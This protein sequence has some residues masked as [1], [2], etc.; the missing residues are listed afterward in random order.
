MSKGIR[1]A[2]LTTF[3]ALSAQRLAGEF[4]ETTETLSPGNVK[5]RRAVCDKLVADFKITL[6]SA[7]S[8]YNA[9]FQHCKKHNPELTVN[10]GRAAD[11]IGGRKRKNADPVVAEAG[12]LSVVNEDLVT[13]VKV[14]D[15]S[16]FAE[17]LTRAAA[18]EMIA[19]H[20]KQRNKPNLMEQVAEVEATV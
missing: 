4:G 11:K 20:A 8:A 9:A 12:N 16:V 7:G 5:F 10:L 1:A 15:G 6:V 17:G 2:A 18:D 19:L 3:I 13:L 14:K